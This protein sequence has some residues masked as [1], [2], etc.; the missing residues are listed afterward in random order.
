VHIGDFE[1]ITMKGLAEKMFKVVG[2]TPKS[3][4]IKNGPVGS[5]KRRLADV[6]KLQK[7]TGWKPEV[8]LEEGLKR[9]FDW[10]LEYPDPT[11]S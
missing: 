9:T 5:V 1:E 10:Y 7:I 4:D 3:L 6:S 11:S 2:W 8:S